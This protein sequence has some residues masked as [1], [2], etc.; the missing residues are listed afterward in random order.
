MDNLLPINE[1]TEVDGRAYLNPQVALDES[2]T[3]IDNLRTA[4][5]QQNQEIFTDT[6]RLGTDVPTNLGGLTGAESYF[7]SRYQTPQTNAVVANLRAT[8]QLAALNQALQNEQAIWK[9]RYQD[10]YNAYQRRAA[11]RASG[12]G[13]GGSGSG[14]GEGLGLDTNENGA[15]SIG[16]SQYTGGEYQSGKLYPV[17]N[18][19]SDYQDASGQWWQV[20]N[21][22]FRDVSFGPTTDP[23]RYKQTNENVVNV[24][25]QDYIY[26]DNVPNREGSWYRVTRSAGPGTYSPYAG[27]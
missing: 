3:F 13:S 11:S 19:V 9:K 25:G 2:N 27:S 1:Y 20:A 12:G 4:Q 5:G 16:I 22:D 15:E 18:Y 26:L 24:N 7:T 17:T 23:I 21:P 8:A 10:A 14:G 6:Q